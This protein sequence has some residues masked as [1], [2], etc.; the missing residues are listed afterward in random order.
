[1]RH[2][3]PL[4]VNNRFSCLEVDN[5]T[6]QVLPILTKGSVIVAPEI[7]PSLP[8]IWKFSELDFVN[9]RNDFPRSML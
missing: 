4:L 6:P 9:G 5:E 2:V 3:P 1:M 8:K 7:L